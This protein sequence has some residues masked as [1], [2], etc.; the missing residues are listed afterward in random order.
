MDL[1][2]LSPGERY[3]SLAGVLLVLDLLVLPWHRISIG[4]GPFGVTASQ[5]AAST[6]SKTRVVY[7]LPSD[8][9]LDETVIPA[10]R[11]ELDIVQRWFDSQTGGTRAPSDEILLSFIPVTFPEQVRCGEGSEAGFAI[12]WMGSCNAT[13]SL[14]STTLGDGATRT[15]A[16]ELVHALGAVA[17][18][19]PHYGRNGHVVDDPRDLLYDGPY[20]SPSGADLQLDPGH[21]DYYRTG[22]PNC[23]DIATHRAWTK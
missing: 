9:T 23:P 5:A 15:I 21:D 18:C 3:M 20:A 13:P 2:R 19:A 12:I 1:K 7:A 22:H 14:R 16:H 4:I 8:A 10:V 11:H 6:P 17:P